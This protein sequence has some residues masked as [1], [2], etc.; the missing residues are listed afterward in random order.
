[1]K[2]TYSITDLMELFNK[3]R[4]TIYRWREN[5]A[6]PEPDIKNANPLWLRSTLERHIPTLTTNP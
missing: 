3:S 1:M 5:G 4:P 6:L 2:N